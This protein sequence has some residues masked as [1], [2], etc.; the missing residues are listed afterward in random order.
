[1]RT[2]R[3]SWRR[4]GSTASV[5]ALEGRTLMAGDVVLEWNAIALETT[6]SLAPALTTQRQTRMMA[7]VHGAVFDAVSNVE[8][9]H[10][11]YLVK[12][13][14]PRWAS[15]E[16]AAAVAAHDVLVA[17]VPAKDADFDAALAASLAAIPDGRAEDAGVALGRT[18]AAA[19]LAHRQD[20][21]FDVTVPHTPGTGPDD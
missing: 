10:E 12:V 7:M 2:K 1:M 13:G 11:P 14:T 15:A 6:R 5:E 9:G 16:A 21:G 8:R 3:G 4:P 17:L 18:V 19:M 20:D